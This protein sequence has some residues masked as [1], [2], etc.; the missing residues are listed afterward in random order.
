MGESWIRTAK[1]CRYYQRGTHE[2]RALDEVNLTID[3]GEFVA[4]VGKS[5]SGKSTLL[6]LIAGLDTPTS[7]EVIVESNSLA[8]M[9]RRQLSQYR[10]QRVGMIFQSFNLL[11][12]RPALQNV[13]MA[14]YFNNHTRSQRRDRA[15]EVLAR[16]GLA[17]RESHRPADLSGGEQQRVAIA[18]AIVKKPQIL[19][20]DEPTGNLDEENSQ[21][22]ADLLSEL[23]Q[24]GLTVLMVTHDQELAYRTAHRIVRMDYG[25]VIADDRLEREDRA[26]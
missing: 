22:I 6:N 16:L 3:R 13:E 2:V 12:Y 9:S 21:L 26:R 5:G 23:N 17:D 7:G 18:R 14:L 10:A 20:A 25:A 1:L 24:E 15:R 4:V 8:S 11:S 19:L